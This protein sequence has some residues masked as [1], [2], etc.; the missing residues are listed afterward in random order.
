MTEPF[1]GDIFPWSGPRIPKGFAP[2][3]GQL[4]VLQRN[5]AL[6]SLIGT[7]YG[8]NGVTNFALPDLGGRVP[9]G[10]GSG[11]GLGEVANGE[12]LGST[13]MPVASSSGGQLLIGEAN[14][15]VAGTPGSNYS[16]SLAIYYII[17]LQGVYPVRSE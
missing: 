7:T 10:A 4:L 1:I 14:A 16:P 13:T 5:L 12:L 17:A 9:V 3:L 2:C 6:Y 11:P 8:G 15:P